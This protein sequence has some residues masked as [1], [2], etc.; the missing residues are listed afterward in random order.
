MRLLPSDANASLPTLSKVRAEMGRRSLAEF[1]RLSWHVLERSTPLEWNWH[2]DAV[3]DHVQALLEGRI[4]KRNLLIN[5]PPGSMKSRIVSVC[6]PAWWWIEHPEWSAIFASGNPRVATRDSVA[7]R[8]LI[9]SRWYRES[10]QPNWT[11]AADQNAKTLYKNTRGGFRQALSANA[12]VTG[13]RAQALFWDD[14]LDA[15][16]AQSHSRAERERVNHWYDQ[17]FANRLADPRSGTRIGICQRLHEDDPAGHVLASGEYEALIIPQIYVPPKPPKDAPADA[18]PPEKPKSSIGWQDPREVEGEMM[19]PKRFTGQFLLAEKKRLGAVGFDAQHNQ[20]AAPDGGILFKR[21]WWKYFTLP[22]GLEGVA[23]LRALGVERLAIGFDTALGTKQANDYSSYH[24]IG[25]AGAR[26]L[27]LDHAKEKLQFPQLKD[28]VTTL[29]AKWNA[30][31]VPI[32]GNG[33]ASGKAIVQALSQS[34]LVP[35]IEVPN[36]AKEVRGARVSP[37]VESGLVYLPDNAPWVE[38]FI[39]SMAIFPKGAHDDDFDSFCITLDHLIFGE[40]TTGLL[41]FYK[42]EKEAMDAA[43]EAAKKA[44]KKAG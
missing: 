24:V 34:S 25:V 37:T 3:C 11:L 18:P 8:D 33:S 16:D 26:Y 28:W 41:G 42:A 32:E 29:H 43:R 1:V 21:S 2:L 44:E 31:A 12:K 19:F 14:L 38:D 40:T 4:P 30:E 36:I 9:E 17:A 6:T 23:L 27:V 35:A 22:P 15:T 20:K 5:V 7:C 39:H 10:F 13:D